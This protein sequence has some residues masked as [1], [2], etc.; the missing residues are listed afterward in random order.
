LEE[1]P[2]YVELQN[3]YSA[4]EASY[5]EL[6]TAHDSIS[7]NHNTLT[8]NYA[9]LE[10]NYNELQSNYSV[11]TQEKESLEQ[12]L[13]PLAQFKKDYD[14]KEKQNMI[15]SFYM[16]SN[17]DKKDV[18][19]NIDNYSLEEIESKLSVICVRN[20]VSF[21]VETPNNAKPAVSYGFN[22]DLE[23][24]EAVPAWVKAALGVAK[25]LN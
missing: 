19:E 8:A 13:E 12:R 24:D 2:E 22:G 25:T 1:I 11:L 4:L 6:K 17:E 3:R 15:D 16:L 18:I 14:K 9:A 10:V 21:S 7:E 23:D 20:R 5:N